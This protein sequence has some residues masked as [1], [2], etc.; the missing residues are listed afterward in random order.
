M[1]DSKKSSLL[2]AV[3]KLKAAKKNSISSQ[4]DGTKSRK[5]RDSAGEELREKIRDAVSK[6]ADE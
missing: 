3:N 4:D 2:S 6:F 5:R 1:A